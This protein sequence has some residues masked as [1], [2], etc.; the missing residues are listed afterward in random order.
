M[1]QS[2]SCQGELENRLSFGMFHVQRSLPQTVKLLTDHAIS[3]SQGGL[4][5][6]QGAINGR[7]EV[8]GAG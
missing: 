5:F 8:Q 1:L 2:C 7:I 6:Q 4:G 3:T